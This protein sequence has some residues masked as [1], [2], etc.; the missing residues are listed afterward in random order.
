MRA[1]AWRPVDINHQWHEASDGPPAVLNL[2]D[3]ATVV[4]EHKTA[5]PTRG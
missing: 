1:L 4:E 5:G 3:A 2:V